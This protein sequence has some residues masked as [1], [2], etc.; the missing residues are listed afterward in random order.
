[1]D[2]IEETWGQMKLTEEEDAQIDLEGEAMED[3]QRKGERCLIGKI[4]IERSIGR[5]ILKST[6][7][8]I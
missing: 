7:A 2:K 4:C 3:I 1:M 6:M 5:A 8:K